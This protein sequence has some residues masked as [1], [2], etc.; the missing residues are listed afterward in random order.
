MD[1]RHI[2]TIYHLGYTLLALGG[3]YIICVILAIKTV[4]LLRRNSATFSTR[5]KQLQQQ[6][7]KVLFMQAVLPVLVSIGPVFA[8]AIEAIFQVE[9][10]QFVQIVLLLLAWLPCLSPLAT[11]CIMKPFHKTLKRV[12][13]MPE[14]SVVS[15]STSV[16]SVI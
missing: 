4:R 7:T 2:Y 15:H 6:M 9:L 1:T 14:N 10:H 11:L 16:P 8:V 12:F 3:S 13:S 5:T